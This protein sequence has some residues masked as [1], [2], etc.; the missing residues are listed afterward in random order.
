LKCTNATQCNM[1]QYFP[2]PDVSWFLHHDLPSV[3]RRASYW[4][5]WSIEG[6]YLNDGLGCGIPLKSQS[7]PHIEFELRN[8]EPPV[9]LIV[10]YS[11]WYTM[12]YW[13][14]WYDTFP[15]NPFQLLLRWG[16]SVNSTN[17]ALQGWVPTGFQCLQTT[18]RSGSKSHTDEGHSTE[19]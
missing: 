11:L 3:L 9:F 12:T 6:A 15:S 7:R 18:L 8:A 19:M 2:T 14:V 4:L 13:H 17:G 1:E 10:S 5:F 16:E